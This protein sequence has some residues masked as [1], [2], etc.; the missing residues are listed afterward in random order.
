MLALYELNEIPYVRM[1][2]NNRVA[3][4]RLY[5]LTNF[6]SIKNGKWVVASETNKIPFFGSLQ[7]PKYLLSLEKKEKRVFCLFHW[8][9]PI[10]R[11]LSYG[12]FLQRTLK[13]S[14]T[15]NAIKNSVCIQNSGP[16][17][18]FFYFFLNVYSG[19]RF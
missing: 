11:S 18:I 7:E 5:T 13:Y 14:P 4:R 17:K 3:N 15:Q 2:F 6:R 19:Y 10:S 16:I 1:F 12:I 8:L 9:Q